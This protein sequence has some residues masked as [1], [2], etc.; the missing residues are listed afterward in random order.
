MVHGH[1]GFDGDVGPVV[2]LCDEVGGGGADT[3]VDG[4]RDMATAVG[5]VA[6]REHVVVQGEA[7]VNEGVDDTVC[8]GGKVVRFCVQG[9][10]VAVGRLVLLEPGL[11][12]EC[13]ALAGVTVSISRKRQEQEQVSADIYLLHGLKE[14][15]AAPALELPVIVVLLAPPDTQRAVAATAAPEEPASTELDLAVV[16]AVH[17]LCDQVPVR[18]RVEVLGP[19]PSHVHIFEIAVVLPGLQEQHAYVLVL[20][21]TAGNDAS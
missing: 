11:G 18:L 4:A 19:A 16:D 9:P 3:L 17:G 5:D 13:L 2:L 15:V 1:V 6:G 10:G 7:L 12:V 8:N 14:L 20:S 21:Q